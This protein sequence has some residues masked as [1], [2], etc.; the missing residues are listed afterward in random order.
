M[1]QSDGSLPKE[2]LMQPQQDYARLVAV[3]DLVADWM[4]RRERRASYGLAGLPDSDVARI[5]RDIGVSAVDLRMLDRRGDQELS[6]PRMMAALM[7]DPAAV[8]RRDP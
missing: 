3:I 4:R 2:G 8:A 1:Q 5:A 6:L 7:L